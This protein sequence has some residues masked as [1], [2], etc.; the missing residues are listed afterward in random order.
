MTFAIFGVAVAWVRPL[1]D[2]AEFVRTT[3]DHAVAVGDSVDPD[4][5]TVTLNDLLARI[6]ARF[7]RIEPRR[8]ATA[9]VHGLLDDIDRKN[10]WN[11][12]E[13]TG[14]TGPQGMQRLLRQAR[15][16]ADEVRDDVRS[17]VVEHLGPGGVLI[18]DE[19]GFE[20]KGTGSAGVQRQYSGTAGR[21]DN[22]Q[23]GVFL[24]YAT[25]A[26]RASGPSP[27]PPGRRHRHPSGLRPPTAT[28][29]AGSPGS[30]ADRACG[31][32]EP[33]HLLGPGRLRLSKCHPGQVTGLA[34]LLLGRAISGHSERQSVR[35]DD[36][37]CCFAWHVSPR[38]TPSSRRGC[39][40]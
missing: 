17:Y 32:R 40:R 35:H 21:I 6:A 3:E 10:C 13:H 14:A 33:C 8:T 22:C 26:G 24:A 28:C 34:G 2:H 39:C 29:K 12:A 27:K 36:Q 38:R 11:L 30:S 16:D 15:W 25:G 20:K 31:R 18:V 37:P 7:G 23:I 19:T 4:Q 9:Y 5:W 1:Q